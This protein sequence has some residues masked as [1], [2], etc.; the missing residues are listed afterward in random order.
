MRRSLPRGVAIAICIG[1][2]M[3]MSEVLQLTVE[4]TSTLATI[5][6]GALSFIVLT[7]VAMPLKW[8]KTGM[9]IVLA[10]AFAGAM[11]LVPW[12]VSITP[13]TWQMLACAAGITLFGG[14][15]MFLL[16]KLASPIIEKILNRRAKCQK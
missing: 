9:I 1:L 10:A 14:V 5:T 3:V 16:E 11:L 7:K 2:V 13:V 4:E 6:M 8:W 12:L 15:L